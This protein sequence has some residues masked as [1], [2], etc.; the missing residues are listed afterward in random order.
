MKQ[1]RLL[2]SRLRPTTPS[3]L[4][5]ERPLPGPAISS[6]TNQHQ[7][8]KVQG[9]PRA[10]QH[11]PLHRE[12]VLEGPLTVSKTQLCFWIPIHEREE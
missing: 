2:E 5:I 11:T 7:A 8:H 1:R 9:L 12:I 10:R 3:R 4:Q 6:A